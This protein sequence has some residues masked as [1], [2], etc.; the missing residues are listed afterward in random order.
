MVVYLGGGHYCPKVGDI[1]RLGPHV[2]VGH[3]LATY[4]LA[5]YFDEGD[6]SDGANEGGSSKVPGGW[7]QVIVEAIDSTCIAFPTKELVVVL[8]K[9]A[10][11]SAPRAAIIA[12]LE[13][14]SVKWSYKYQKGEF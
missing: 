5:G 12:F 3:V 10:F 4:A 8:E 1:A 7:Q 13:E 6:E 14:R 2:A 9:K 11:K